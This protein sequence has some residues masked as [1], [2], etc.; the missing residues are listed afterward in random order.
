[1]ELIANPKHVA[2]KD[3]PILSSKEVSVGDMGQILLPKRAAM[4]DAATIPK[5]EGSV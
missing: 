3:V 5:E 4:M 1:M 2:K